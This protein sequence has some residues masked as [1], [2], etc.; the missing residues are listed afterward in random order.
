VTR[1]GTYLRPDIDP[2]N[3][4]ELLAAVDEEYDLRQAGLLP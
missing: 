2:T 1:G 4:S 3:T